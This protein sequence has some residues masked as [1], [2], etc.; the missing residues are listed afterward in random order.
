MKNQHIATSFLIIIISFML[1]ACGQSG[2]E[3]PIK[4]DGFNF[5]ITNVEIKDEYQMGLGSGQTLRPQSNF[6]QLLIVSAEMEAMYDDVVFDDWDVEVEGGKGFFY[7][8]FVQSKNSTET[9]ESTSLTWIFAVHRFDDSFIFHI[10]DA[11]IALDSLLPEISDLNKEKNAGEIENDNV[12]SISVEMCDQE[13]ALSSEKEIEIYYLVK[14]GDED[15]AK[16]YVDDA[17]LEVDLD[18]ERINM[19]PGEV[20][21]DPDYGTFVR[22]NKNIGK[23]NPGEHVIDAKLIFRINIQ[24]EKINYGSYTT[25]ENLEFT[26]LINSR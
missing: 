12:I 11:E 19:D 15:L 26:C 18:G 13:I 23:L 6:D 20:L 2:V 22:I 14:V 5:Q 1:T 9:Q 10:N 21:H 4:I 17:Q 8:S 7:T 25:N 3:R 16:Q 24:D